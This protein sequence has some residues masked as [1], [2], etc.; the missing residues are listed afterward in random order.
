MVWREERISRDF[1]ERGRVERR[2]PWVTLKERSPEK[3]G[4]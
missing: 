4:P 3:G 1:R 2:L